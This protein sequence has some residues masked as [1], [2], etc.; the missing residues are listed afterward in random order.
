MDLETILLILAI[1]GTILFLVALVMS[2][3]SWRWHTILLVG[4]VFTAG[5]VATWMS[6]ETLKV[7]QSWRGILF[8]DD[9]GKNA[10]PELTI[11]FDGPTG[12]IK[13][14]ETLR[15]ENS[16]IKFGKENDRG[17]VI[18]PGIVQLQSQLAAL[19]VDR[20]RL[21][22]DVDPLSLSAEDI[23]VVE[24]PQTQTYR[25]EKK[26]PLYLFS[27]K[28][29][30]EGGQ[31]LGVF[32]VEEVTGNVSEQEEAPVPAGAK[33]R[34]TLIPG[35][36]ISDA[37]RDR[38]SASVNDKDKWRMY[39][40][41]PVDRHQVFA[42]LR[43]NDMKIDE[44]A[45]E[46]MDTEERLRKILPPQSVPEYVDD[47]Q[48]ARDE[49]P[50][51]R[52]EELVEF[53]E[54]YPDEDTESHFSEGQLVWLPRIGAKGT[55]EIRDSVTGGTLAVDAIPAIGVLIE[56]EIIERV[57]EDG[58]PR[59]S[60]KLRDY[61]YL[62][63]D[64]YRQRQRQAFE[65]AEKDVEI[66]AVEKVIA[67]KQQIIE[68]FEKEKGRLTRDRQQFLRDLNII[69]GLTTL[70]DNQQTVAVRTLAEIRK[71]TVRLGEEL[72]AKQ[73]KA[74]EEI[75]RRLPDPGVPAG[76]G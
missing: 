61:A 63:R 8:L 41:T 12:L 75:D 20:G 42:D 19:L 25:I 40:K 51:E 36:P 52:I 33:V 74:V 43:A 1:L 49:H 29:P 27:E 45:F 34:V 37:E 18:Q 31:Y 5:G 38:L 48:P 22:N 30:L 7:H 62:F 64:L 32:R 17:E 69:K 35:W 46:Q 26:V 11:R 72:N 15:Q 71:E 70:M 55:V 59:Y 24:V 56:Q 16:E 2:Y 65:I 23:L 10:D 54:D 67:E 44:E 68:R 6:V 39:D 21:W 53:L 58:S 28:T 50:D 3:K 73:L 60:R 14:T 66:V 13:K 9:L 4:L 76:S 47:Y 57:E